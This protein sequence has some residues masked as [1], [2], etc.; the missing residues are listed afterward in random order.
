MLHMISLVLKNYPFSELKDFFCCYL[1]LETARLV[2]ESFS[3]YPEPY[4]AGSPSLHTI[5][6]LTTWEGVWGC[7]SHATKELPIIFFWNRP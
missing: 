1:A 5:V 7:D 4:I 2:G 3:A 6:Q